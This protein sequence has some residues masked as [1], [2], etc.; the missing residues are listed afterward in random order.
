M[1]TLPEDGSPSDGSDS[2]NHPDG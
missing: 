2:L 1:E